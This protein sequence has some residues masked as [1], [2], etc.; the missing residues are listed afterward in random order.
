MSTQ[1]A[2]ADARRS[3]QARGWMAGCSDVLVSTTPLCVAVGSLFDES[4]RELKLARYAQLAL[5]D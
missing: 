4:T 1:A 2:A 5:E 3:L